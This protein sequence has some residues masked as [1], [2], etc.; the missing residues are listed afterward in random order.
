MLFGRRVAETRDVGSVGDPEQALAVQAMLM[1]YN[2]LRQE[3]LAAISNR[4]TIAN[5]TFGA[6]AIILAALMT[7]AKPSALTA[8]VALVFVPQVS[9]VGLMIWLGEYNRSQR[10]G[11][12]AAELE[13][14]VSA[15]IGRDRVMAWESALLSNSIHMTYPYLS[16]V[17]LLLGVGW[18]SSTIGATLLLQVWGK[19]ALQFPEFL[20]AIAGALL[21]VIVELM[22]VRFFRAKWVAVKRNY[23]KSGPEM[24]AV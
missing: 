8:V 14:R 5:F 7:Q 16:V 3:S 20:L 12:W 24:W 11:K 17:L 6:V 4:V 10:A 9:K 2:S 21:I 1:E 23:S 18:A 22:F 15:T 19:T 13:V